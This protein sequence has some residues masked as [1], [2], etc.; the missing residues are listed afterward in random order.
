MRLEGV[1]VLKV[2]PD[3]P[4]ASEDVV[5]EELCGRFQRLGAVILLA[6]MDD[7]VIFIT[8]FPEKRD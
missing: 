8:N 2:V 4:D 6:E 3:M 1:E 5:S 7:L